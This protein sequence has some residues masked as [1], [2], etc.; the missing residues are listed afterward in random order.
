MNEKV[1]WTLS[2]GDYAEIE[3]LY[4]KKMA[5]ENLLKVVSGDSE[6]LYQRVLKDYG[7]ACHIFSQWWSDK[8]LEYDWEKGK[9]WYLNFDTHE[10][11]L[12]LE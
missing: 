8:S 9:S 2:D 11:V 3:E 6:D 4:E 12:V 5:L 10:I 7:H 1:I